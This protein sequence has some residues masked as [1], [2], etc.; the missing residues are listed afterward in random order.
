MA[1]PIISNTG[2][3]YSLYYNVI[4]YFKTIMSNHPSLASA[5]FGDGAKFDETEFPAYPLA[6]IV[7]LES[8][9]GT[10]ITNYKV[11]LIVA[12]K[13]KNKNNESNPTNNEQ[14]VP[15]YGP[16]DMVDI[17]ANTMSIMNDITAF[18]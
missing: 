2:T 1:N 11:Q 10:N 4:N 6:S 9:F 3:N 18:I 15:F 5:A 12:D 13:V 8:D 7:I 14:A 17:W 16:D